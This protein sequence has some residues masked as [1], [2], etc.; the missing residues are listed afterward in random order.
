MPSICIIAGEASGDAQGALL[1]QALKR[2]FEHNSFLNKCEFW[3]AAGP[4]LIQEGVEPLVRVE[5]LCVLGISEIIPKYLSIS[6][7]YKKLLDEIT[8]KKPIAVI[9]IDYPGFNLKLIQEVYNLGM[10]TLYHIPP[11]AWSH[12]EKRTEILKKYSYLVTCIL[13]FEEEYFRSKNV[14]V[15]FIG[16]PLKDSIDQFIS[17]HEIKKEKYKIAIL[18]GS[19]E[20]EIKKLLP[21]LI[22][23]FIELEKAENKVV[24]YIPIAVTVS[25]Q[26]LEKILSEIKSKFNLQQEWFDKKIKIGF[27]NAHEVLN[28]CEYAWVCSGTATL[29]SAFFCTPMSVMYKVS[30]LTALWAK[31][32]LK[33]KYVSLVNLCTNKETIPEFLQQNANAKNLIDHA[34]FILKNAD[35][36][37]KMIAELT[38]LRDLFP[39]HAASNAARSMT[40]CILKYNLSSDEKFNTHI[41]SL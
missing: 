24:A 27:G 18:P 21:I 33:I 40:E 41:K 11:K 32:Y 28:S 30:P 4:L 7:L 3:G 23:A 38:A 1:V 31:K 25:K 26:F 37:Q 2:E 6:K 16:N 14:P 8:R 10:T 5:D 35:A 20:N 9:F 17:T 36:K 12:G 19:R 39:P 34:L 13:P 22:E 15:K 29:E